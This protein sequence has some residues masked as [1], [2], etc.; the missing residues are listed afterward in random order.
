MT[1]KPIFSLQKYFSNIF[2]FSFIFDCATGLYVIK[3]I[4]NQRT[5]VIQ[6]FFQ[7]G[8]FKNKP[9]PLIREKKCAMYFVSLTFCFTQKIN[10]LFLI[11]YFQLY[12][13]L[14]SPILEANALHC[15]PRIN[16]LNIVN[17]TIVINVTLLGSILQIVSGGKNKSK[18]EHQDK[19]R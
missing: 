11:F 5:P 2:N 13:T 15:N 14:G 1:E 6:T 17:D 16:G 8:A 3:A 4:L 19:F 7:R 10:V 9:T 12:L 18:T